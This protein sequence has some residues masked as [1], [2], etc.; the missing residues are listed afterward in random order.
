MKQVKLMS[1]SDSNCQFLPE[2]R[3][4]AM[5]VRRSHI[6][7]VKCISFNDKTDNK[8]E[9]GEGGRYKLRLLNNTSILSKAQ[10]QTVMIL[11]P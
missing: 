7:K 9:R 3:N 6:V 11:I 1:S 10:V 8:R 4:A 5:Q 2:D